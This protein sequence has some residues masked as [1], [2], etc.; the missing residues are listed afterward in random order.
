MR[1]EAIMKSVAQEVE[2]MASTGAIVGAGATTRAETVRTGT[3]TGEEA[4]TTKMIAISIEDTITRTITI[5]SK[6][7]T[8]IE[9]AIK[10]RATGTTIKVK[11]LFI[12]AINKHK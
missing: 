1:E 2:A 11:E 10:T 7:P 6:I 3:G 5:K 4:K 8:T 9:T 12:M